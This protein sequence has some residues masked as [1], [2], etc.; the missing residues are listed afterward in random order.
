MQEIRATI[1]ALIAVVTLTG[2]NAALAATGLTILQPVSPWEV[3][4]ADDV[5]ELARTFGHGPDEVTIEFRQFGPGKTFTLFAAGP[6]L[7]FSTRARGLVTDFEP[8]GRR[9]E[10][11]STFVGTLQDGRSVAEVSTSMLPP[12]QATVTGGS[13]ART[14]P[15]VA[16]EAKPL[17]YDREAEAKVTRLRLSGPIAHDIVL[18]LGPMD[19][20]MDAMRACIDELLTHWGVDAAAQRT[21]TRRAAPRSNPGAWAMPGD[22]PASMLRAGKSAVVHFRLM[23]DPTGAPTKCIIQTSG[24]D[25]EFDKITCSLMMQRARFNPALDA[26]GRP[27]ASFYVSSIRWMT[28]G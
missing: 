17:V 22:Y 21:L 19:K 1:A 10:D 23:I 14:T 9:L 28:P 15:A 6:S 24:D 16:D 4:Y 20:P 26:A 2:P 3:N 8:G 12:D 25:P 5:C 11:Q 27:I 18:E 7:K 13:A